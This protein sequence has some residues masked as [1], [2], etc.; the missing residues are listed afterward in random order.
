M[1]RMFEREF[2]DV[3]PKSVHTSDSQ[4]ISIKIKMC[5]LN[6]KAEKNV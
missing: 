4:Q 6:I 1:L 5:D 2:Q 3:F